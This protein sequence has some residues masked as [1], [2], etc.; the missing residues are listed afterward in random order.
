MLLP[1]PLRDKRD[2]LFEVPKSWEIWD[3][4]EVFI[5]LRC[6]CNLYAPLDK[7][8]FE[9]TLMQL[10][11]D[12]QCKACENVAVREAEPERLPDCMKTLLIKGLYP[13]SRVLLFQN[14]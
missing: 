2:P 3:K 5:D 6:R 10:M 1:C 14:Y 12:V 11:K 4:F 8:I 7:V 13:S 9:Y